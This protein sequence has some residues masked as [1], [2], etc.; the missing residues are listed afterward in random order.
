MNHNPTKD[1]TYLRG[2][3]YNKMRTEFN[4]V[5]FHELQS[6]A[7]L[8]KNQFVPEDLDVKFNE[9]CFLTE[10]SIK[11]PDRYSSTVRFAIL[12]TLQEETPY[13]QYQ[14]Y[15]IDACYQISEFVNNIQSFK[16]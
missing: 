10:V 16:I 15:S 12:S 14:V 8:V 3:L 4:A 2:I 13:L 5:R 11:R 1:Y 7:G 6:Y 9:Q